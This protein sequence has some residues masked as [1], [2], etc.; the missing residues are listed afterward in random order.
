RY[1]CGRLPNPERV[2]LF[3]DGEYVPILSRPCSSAA[4]PFPETERRANPRGSC[5]RKYPGECAVR[6]CRIILPSAPDFF[7]QKMDEMSET[8][9]QIDGFEDGLSLDPTRQQSTGD[10]VRQLIGVFERLEVVEYFF[11]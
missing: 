9:L 5:Q 6:S 1:T 11:W 2:C 3:L 7:H 4:P 10:Q 8:F